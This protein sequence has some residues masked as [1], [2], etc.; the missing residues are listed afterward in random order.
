MFIRLWPEAGGVPGPVAHCPV[1]PPSH[2]QAAHTHA[3]SNASPSGRISTRR[4]NLY[5]RLSKSSK[6]G[7]R[8]VPSETF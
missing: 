3:Q 2:C 1:P 8:L 7:L 6:E 4:S 5:Q